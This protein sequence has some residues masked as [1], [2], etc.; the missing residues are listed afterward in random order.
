MAGGSGGI[1]QASPSVE[2]FKQGDLFGEAAFRRPRAGAAAGVASRFRTLLAKMTVWT[3]LLLGPVADGRR[4][5]DA[6]QAAEL[7][8]RE[9]VL[10]VLSRHGRPLSFGLFRR[11]P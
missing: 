8:E 10:D 11:L 3:R 2:A 4:L 1:F 9:G 7:N 6:R 5:V